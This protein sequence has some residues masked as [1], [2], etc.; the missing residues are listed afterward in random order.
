[1]RWSHESRQPKPRHQFQNHICHFLEHRKPSYE[2]IISPALKYVS[3]KNWELSH[4]ISLLARTSLV[5]YPSLLMSYRLKAQ[6]SF[7]WIVPRRRIERPITKS[8]RETKH[9]LVTSI[10]WA[11]TIIYIKKTWSI[12]SILSIGGFSA[13][14]IHQHF[15]QRMSWSGINEKEMMKQQVRRHHKSKHTSL[16]K[17][18]ADS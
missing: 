10:F 5:I 7:S 6:L 1:M 4:D 11:S 12:N 16:F 18:L 15:L 8:C 2:K 13:D 9:M 3:N 17:L 14:F